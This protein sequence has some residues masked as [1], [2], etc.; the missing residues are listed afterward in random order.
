M[1]QI[2]TSPFEMKA[3]H[4][5]THKKKMFGA[6]RPN[7]RAAHP[8]R[9]S[10]TFPPHDAD[11]PAQKRKRKRKR[12]RAAFLIFSLF[13]CSRIPLTYT[14]PFSMR[15]RSLRMR[16]ISST[17]PSTMM[18]VVMSSSAVTIFTLTCSLRPALAM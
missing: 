6:T 7:T 18:S 12:K 1:N 17:S 5:R 3:H 8:S 15:L 14:L 4:T 13:Y 2:T 10:E 11:F 16:S 9:G